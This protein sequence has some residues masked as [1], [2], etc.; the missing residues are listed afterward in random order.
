MNDISQMQS[1]AL[2]YDRGQQRGRFWRGL[3]WAIAIIIAIITIT[4]IVSCATPPEQA[5]SY[6]NAMWKYWYGGCITDGIPIDTNKGD[7]YFQRALDDER[8]M[9]K[10]YRSPFN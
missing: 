1:V 5:Y 10:R 8:V 4:H 7:Y 3:G 9:Y 6:D 2:N